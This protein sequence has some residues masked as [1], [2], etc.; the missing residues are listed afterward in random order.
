METKFGEYAG[1]YSED[2]GIYGYILLDTTDPTFNVF[3]NFYVYLFD[4]SVEDD[5]IKTIYES[6]KIQNILNNIEFKS[7]K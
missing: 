3:V 4:D 2:D 6:S 5:E 7:S 1:Y